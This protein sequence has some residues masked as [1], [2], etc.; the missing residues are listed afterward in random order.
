MEELKKAEV[1][2]L[3]SDWDKIN[4]SVCETYPEV[5]LPDEVKEL[6]V[7]KFITEGDLFYVEWPLLK[8]TINYLRMFDPLKGNMDDIIEDVLSNI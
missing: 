4:A 8:D 3:H 5:F 7:V 2:K 6:D 1:K